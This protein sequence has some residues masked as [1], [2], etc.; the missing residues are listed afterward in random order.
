MTQY[1]KQRTCRDCLHYKACFANGILYRAC[2]VS[3]I[4]DSTGAMCDGDDQLWTV[5]G[6]FSKKSEW[7]HL[8]CKAGDTVFMPWE[9]NGASGIARLRILWVAFSENGNFIDTVNTN[10][11]ND[12]LDY[13]LKY[14]FVQFDFDDFGRRVFHTEEEAEKALAERRGK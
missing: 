13:L 3:G 10:L 7:V 8:P 9:W 11:E 5:C 2:F 4:C 6:Y 1:K 14:G 12:D